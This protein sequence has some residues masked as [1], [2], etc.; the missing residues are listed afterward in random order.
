MQRQR[1]PTA[2]RGVFGGGEPV[3]PDARAKRVTPGPSSHLLGVVEA[4][5]SSDPEEARTLVLEIASRVR[6]HAWHAGGTQQAARAAALA[7]RLQ[8]A[9]DSG[10]LRSL[11]AGAR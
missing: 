5:L 7:D 6:A 3:T 4:L 1:V 9:G 8:R 11:F 10:D 2:F